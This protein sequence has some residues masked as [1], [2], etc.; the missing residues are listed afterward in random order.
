MILTLLRSASLQI[1]H[2][3]YIDN[4]STEVQVHAAEQVQ[5]LTLEPCSLL[6]LSGGLIFYYYSHLYLM[7]CP[8]SINFIYQS[9][10][11]GPSRWDWRHRVLPIEATQSEVHAAP[12]ALS[13]DGKNAALGRISIVLGC[14]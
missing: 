12:L 3:D 13:P 9:K 1:V 11:E 5:T 6:I 8:H 14:A 7:T 4:K 2:K 10:R